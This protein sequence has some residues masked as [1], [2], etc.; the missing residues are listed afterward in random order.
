MRD[1]YGF[2]KIGVEVKDPSTKATISSY[3]KE[4][5]E[6][7]HEMNNIKT[8]VR[9]ISA[10]RDLRSIGML[11][12]PKSRIQGGLLSRGYGLL[13]DDKDKE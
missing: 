5:M 3:Q 12:D 1:G 7:R 8:E 10:P 9:S 2:A 6:L 13:R 4:L 11:S